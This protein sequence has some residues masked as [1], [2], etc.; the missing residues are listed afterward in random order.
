[1]TFI[2]IVLG[3]VILKGKR[4]GE[5]EIMIEKMEGDLEVAVSTLQH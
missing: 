3:F 5:F 2:N 1:V 4:G